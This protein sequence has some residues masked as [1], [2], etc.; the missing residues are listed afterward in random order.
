MMVDDLL[1]LVEEHRPW[2]KQR[3][4]PSYRRLE[5][6]LMDE[7]E[8]YPMRKAKARPADGDDFEPAQRQRKRDPQWKRRRVV[9]EN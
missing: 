6:Y 1:E 3:G 9:E 7:L 5:D 2:R 4:K 8:G